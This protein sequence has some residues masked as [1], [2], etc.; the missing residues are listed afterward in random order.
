MRKNGFSLVEVL[1]VV[2]VVGI[3]GAL[4]VIGYS[5]WQ[6]SQIATTTPTVTKPAAPQTTTPVAPTVSTTKDLDAAASTL[7]QASG[8]NNTA[9]DTTQLLSQA[10][11]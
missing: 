7:D 1:I 5:R 2:L 6:Q 10:S 11:F 3:I 4:G 9:A 8:A